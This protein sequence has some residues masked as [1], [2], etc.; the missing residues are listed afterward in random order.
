MAI[1]REKPL[2][3]ICGN[4]LSVTFRRMGICHYCIS[5]RRGTEQQTIE[6]KR[7]MYG[8]NVG[9]GPTGIEPG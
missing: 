1:E 6:L 4:E 2:C 3:Y 7:P 5:A 9:T 8:R